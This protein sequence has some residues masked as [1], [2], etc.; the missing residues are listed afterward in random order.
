MYDDDEKCASQ[1]FDYTDLHEE[2]EKL[3][4][5]VD[6]GLREVGWFALSIVG[7]GEGPDYTFT[8]GLALRGWP[9]L[10]IYGLEPDTAYCALGNAI[11]EWTKLGGPPADRSLSNEV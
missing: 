5:A 8:I 7:E 11:Q 9:D 3:F 4:S 10:V 2:F 1:E 6:E